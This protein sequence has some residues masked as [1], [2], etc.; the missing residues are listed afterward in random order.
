MRTLLESRSDAKALS[1][2]RTLWM[3]EFEV[4]PAPGDGTL[5]NADLHG[6]SLSNVMD[7]HERALIASALADNTPSYLRIV[8]FAFIVIVGSAAADWAT[9]PAAVAPW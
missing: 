6:R 9:W 2:Y 1:H 7:D 4:H 8:V 3:L 5:S